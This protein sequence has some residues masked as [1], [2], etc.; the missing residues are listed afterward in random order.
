MLR[1]KNGISLHCVLASVYFLMLPLT[2]AVNSAG[3]SF[4]KI[5]TVPIGLYFAISLLFY[6][7]EFQINLVHIALVV[8]TLSTVVTLFMANDRVSVMTVMGYFLNAALYISMSVVPYNEK[9]LKVFEYVQVALLVIIIVAT[10]ADDAL[11]IADRETLT[12]F[13][14]VSDPNYFVGFLVFPLSV[15]LEKTIK[16]RWRIFYIILVAVGIY[17]VFLS[18]SRGGLLAII[19][20]VIAFAVIYPEGIHNK[21]LVMIALLGGMLA[22]WV[23]LSPILPEHIVERMSVE[24]V[25][26]TRGTYR[27][28]IWQSMLEEIKNSGWEVIFG[29][30]IAVQNIMMIAG[31][32]A[33]VGA[34]NYFIQLIYNQGI[35]GF[36]LFLFL[37]ITII[38]KCIK[39]QKNV[40]VALIGMLILVM[41][42]SVNPSIK[43][44]WNIIP[45]AAFAIADGGNKEFEG[46]ALENES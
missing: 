34:H 20:T 4:L 2:I 24:A 15:V 17:T 45:Y 16:S 42:L 40:V 8:F 22:L 25:V 30:G 5:A 36:V 3:A 10:L 39:K 11:G 9:E 7:Q 35:I 19:I 12:V 33:A 28:D 41:S 31:E 27:A 29:R 6:K 38:A 23:L 18:G 32:K 13:G 43:T 44:L 37:V 46:G 14:Q 26:E 21:V 1:F